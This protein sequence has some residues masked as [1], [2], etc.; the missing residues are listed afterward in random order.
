M[1][2]QRERIETRITDFVATAN[3][4][5]VGTVVETGECLLDVID[6]RKRVKLCSTG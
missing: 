6:R 3:A 1:A 2:G 5:S 4:S